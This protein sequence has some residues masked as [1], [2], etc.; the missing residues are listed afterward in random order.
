MSDSFARNKNRK[1][2][3]RGR[4]EQDR[5]A[6]CPACC[7][8]ILETFRRNVSNGICPD[9]KPMDTAQPVPTDIFDTG[10]SSSLAMDWIWSVFTQTP[11]T[12][13]PQYAMINALKIVWKRKSIRIR[14]GTERLRLVRGAAVPRRIP[15]GA[16][17][18]NGLDSRGIRVRPLQRQRGRRS[19]FAVRQTEVVPRF[20]A[21]SGRCREDAAVWGL[22]SRT[23]RQKNKGDC[24]K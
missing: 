18:L 10:I 4:S 19:A 23:D 7:A 13:P 3:F 11:L 12:I 15:L 20:T 1:T 8:L 5:S 24:K 21:S 9:A 2:A 6:L 17:S 22:F 14:A 16:D